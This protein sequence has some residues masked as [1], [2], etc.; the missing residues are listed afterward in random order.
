MVKNTHGGNKSKSMARKKIDGGNS[1]APLRLPSCDLEKI[2]IVDKLLGNGMFYAI[3]Y[4]SI[5]LLGRIRNKFKGRSRRGN[6]VSVGKLVLIGLREWEMPNPKECDLLLVYDDSQID[7]LRLSNLDI[8]HH[9]DSFDSSHDI[10]FSDE[11][12]NPIELSTSHIYNNTL[13][14]HI[15]DD[16]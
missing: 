7:A 14:D 13:D 12:D 11:T 10:I 3:T 2:A 1:S 5:K 9:N 6:D 15:I 16:I 8:P 4:D